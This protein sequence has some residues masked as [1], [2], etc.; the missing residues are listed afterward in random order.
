MKKE[1]WKESEVRSFPSEH[2]QFERKSGRLVKDDKAF[3]ESLAKALSAMANSHGGHIV[4]G[5]AND[6]SIDGVPNVIKGRQSTREWL[7]QIIPNLLEY[8]LQDFRVHEAEPDISTSIPSDKVVIVIDVGDSP[9]APHQDIFTRIYFHRV[10][11]HSE[12]APH[13]YLD[14]LRSREKYPNQKVAHTWLNFVIR[15]FLAKLEPEQ[16][17]LNDLTLSWNY[18]THELG[19]IRCFYVRA[20]A[21]TPNQMQFLESYP[22]I[23]LEMEEHDR[24]VNDLAYEVARLAESIQLSNTFKD[25]YAQSMSEESLN[26]VRRKIAARADS[27]NREQLLQSL[28]GSMSDKERMKLL[29]QHIV[30]AQ[31]ELDDSK[32]VAPLWNLVRREFMTVMEDDFVIPDNKA[33]EKAHL[34]LY[35]NVTNLIA[36]LEQTRNDLA[37]KHGEVWEDETLSPTS[38]W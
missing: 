33:R 17:R 24:L 27:P 4:L 19:G 7:E 26:A 5:V 11:S 30:N 2:D 16:K 36:M 12:P 14:L 29:A 15:P 22:E 28:F 31:G 9:L 34:A 25:V 10:G 37:R 35:T 21:L 32:M 23:K 20:D 8:P 13:R 18:Q 1:R 38:E 6:G 3:R